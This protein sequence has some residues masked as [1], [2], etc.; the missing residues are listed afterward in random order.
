M[1]IMQILVQYS[2]LIIIAIVL[3]ILI[4]NKKIDSKKLM[5]EIEPYFSFL[6]EDDYEFLLQ[7]KYG[8]GT[9]EDMN[10]LYNKRLR[11]GLIVLL[12]IFIVMSIGYDGNFIVTILLSLLGGYLAFKSKYFGLKSSY[13]KHL[14]K[15]NLMLPYYLKS[16]EILI[17]H[18]TVPVAI[19][20]SIETAPDIFKEGLR[21]LVEKIE[22]GDS[23]VNPYMDFA[24]KYPVRDSMRMMRL[25]YRLS[26]GSQES[27]QQQLLMFSHNVSV[28]QNKARE[29]RYQERL[30]GMEK[31]TLIMLF[32]TGGIILA[33]LMIAIFSMMSTSGLY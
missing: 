17:Q 31:R 6:K 26:L 2:L 23:S 10:Y 21:E 24:K 19:N 3:I 20:K 5:S 1:D 16:L 30:E 33:L 8:D 15:I 12:L 11:D 29:Q 9:K 32:G 4:V 22:A 13:K 7:A 27:K 14:Y 28:L 18:Y 25:L